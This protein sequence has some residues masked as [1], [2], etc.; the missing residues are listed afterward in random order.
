MANQ[1]PAFKNFICC[2]YLNYR[3]APAKHYA[4][5]THGY[6]TIQTPEYMSKITLTCG[7]RRRT[8]ESI[9][10]YRRSVYLW[11][12]GWFTTVLHFAR[13]ITHLTKLRKCKQS[14]RATGVAGPCFQT[15]FIILFLL[16]QRLDDGFD[17][18]SRLGQLTIGSM[19]YAYTPPLLHRPAIISLTNQTSQTAERQGRPLTLSLYQLLAHYNRS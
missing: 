3:T 13:A 8:A 17:F 10:V 18:A 6:N 1:Y 5:T 7:R 2:V 9:T 14:S 11:T 15:M 12:Y 16:R 4:V 19:N